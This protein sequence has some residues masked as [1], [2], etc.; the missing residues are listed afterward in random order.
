AGP[1]VMSHNSVDPEDVWAPPAP[2]VTTLGFSEA[3]LAEA[4]PDGMLHSAWMG[5][6]TVFR[7]VSFVVGPISALL[8]IP[9][10]AL[11]AFGLGSGR[12]LG[13]HQIVPGAVG[14]SLVCSLCG[15][16]IG[17]VL[18]LIGAWLRKAKP[19]GLAAR[20]W[21]ALDRPVGRSGRRQVEGS[22]G[23]GF[24]RRHWPWLVGAPALLAIACG[25]GTGAYLGRIVDRR[26]DE[27]IAAA[28]RE[29]PNWR[30]DDLLAHR[31][32][33]PDDEN[34]ALVVAEELDGLPDTWDPLIAAK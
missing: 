23:P 5:A 3:P 21:N 30:L 16:I 29:D 9:G 10:L 33:V 2:T 20:V 15:G 25:L 26:L 12:G 22:R 4:P 31:D 7:L 13:V 34:A 6:R 17:A 11:S 8:L 32:V 14:F 28:D 18:G 19:G 1:R 27:A 24:L